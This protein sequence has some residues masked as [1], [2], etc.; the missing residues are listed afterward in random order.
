MTM[1]RIFAAALLLTAVLAPQRG[2]SGQ[3]AN[4]AE[5]P[6]V[7]KLVLR[8]TIQPMSE[9]ILARALASAA[10]ERDAALV[11][12]LNT[13]GGLLESTR[14]I[15]Q[16]M[17][18]SP[19]PVIIFVAPT[20]ARAASAGFFLLEA[21]DVA[22]MAPGTNTGAAHPVLEGQTLDPVMKEKLEN[23]AA[24]F[25]RSYAARR[26]RNVDAA[27]SAI[28]ES[29]AFGDQEALNLKL[30][31]FIAADDAD[32]LRQLNGRP[33]TRFDGSKLTLQLAGAQMVEIR[34]TL[35]ENILDKLMDPNLAL[36]ILLLGALL[37]YLEFHIPGTVVPGAAGALLVLLAA[38]SLN[39]LPLHYASVALLIC[40]LL[41]VVGEAKFPSHGLLSLVGTA[42]VIFGML[43]LVNAP[44]PELRIRLATTLAAAL[45]FG[46]ITFV[47]ARMAWRA[48]QNKVKTGM[49]AL[50]G[51]V[52]VAQTPLEPQGQVLVRGE[53]WTA[54]CPQG[55]RKGDSVFV[56][57]YHDLTLEVERR[58]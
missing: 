23:D 51:E 5:H 32:L 2:I 26:G 28:R 56:R 11:I 49:Q 35:R 31:D 44:V 54:H 17:E 47:V 52:A 53:L 48:R 16:H 13:P 7:A 55:A 46:A 14:N 43:T 1:R 34:P 9:E 36:V 37:I 58:G 33:I 39:L 12:E 29:K 57:G 24:A 8:D 6:K 45:T 41:L 38:F 10:D 22:V 50:L 40:G 42:A 20:G 3:Q 25:L 4:P 19:V 21:A 15:V 18:Q 27:E 30:I